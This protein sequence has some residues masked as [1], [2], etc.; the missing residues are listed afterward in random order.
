MRLPSGDTQE[1]A[2]KNRA[3]ALSDKWATAKAKHPMTY[4]NI[5]H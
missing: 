5:D 2:R 1:V 3:E 4:G